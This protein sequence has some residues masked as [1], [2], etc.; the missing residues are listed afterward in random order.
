VNEVTEVVEAGE[1]GQEAG[2]LLERVRSSQGALVIAEQG[3]AAAVL[4]SAARYE[5][6]EYERWLLRA[7]LRGEQEIAAGH[8]HD[9]DDVLTD[10]DAI[11]AD[12]PA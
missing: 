12:G 5:H 8:G 10:A 2:A 4:L 11:L 7:L 3:R 1:L 6:D 9:L